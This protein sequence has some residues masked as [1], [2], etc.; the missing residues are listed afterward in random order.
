MLIKRQFR[1]FQSLQQE[2]HKKL[3]LTN[4]IR[5]YLSNCYKHLSFPNILMVFS[6]YSC[7][8]VILSQLHSILQQKN[9]KAEEL[10]HQMFQWPKHHLQKQ[11]HFQDWQ[12]YTNSNQY[13]NLLWEWIIF[14]SFPKQGIENHQRI[15]QFK[16][17]VS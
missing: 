17:C 12:T 15:F 6:K 14:E 10:K 2:Y 1:H 16:L 5:T 3:V 11:K 9:Y 7:Y 8:Q 13:S 4:Q